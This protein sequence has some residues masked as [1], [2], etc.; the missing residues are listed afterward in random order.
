MHI[1]PKR[2]QK[3]DTLALLSPS[4]GLSHLF[5][6]RVE[7]A[8]KYLESIGYQVRVLNT[9]YALQDKSAG[10]IQQRLDD[11]HNAFRDSEIRGIICNIGGLSANELVAHLDYS[12]IR[13]HPKVFCGYSDVTLLLHAIAR[14]AG[15]VV[16]YGPMSM[17]QFGEY[18]APLDYTIEHFHRAVSH[19]EPIGAISPSRE[20]TDEI[21]DWREKLDLTR[22]R[23]MNASSGYRWLCSG[24][25][26]ASLVGGCLYS[27]RQIIGT[28][29]ALDFEGC[30][31]FIETPPGEDGFHGLPLA[32]FD[33]QLMDLDN[34]GVLGSIVGL[35]VGR[36]FAY[37]A[38]DCER[39]DQIIL[40]H[41]QKYGYPVLTRVDIGHTDPIIT[42]PLTLRA[43]MD[44]ESNTFSIIEAAVV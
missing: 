12:L 20:W 3:G 33:S 37:G 36:P 10:T 25:A 43:S 1:K 41:V 16:F 17:T 18:P 31:L 19:A 27:L 35:I 5:P 7:R 32:Y 9:S 21:L 40:K 15:L 28:P 2:L 4:S 34:L 22:P 6:H 29:Y 42:V 14:H 23:A 11:I 13:S 44:S 30:I 26:E 39:A 24:R 8:A 38:D